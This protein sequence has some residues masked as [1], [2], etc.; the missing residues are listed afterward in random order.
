MRILNIA[1]VVSSVEIQTDTTDA[2]FY[3]RYYSRSDIFFIVNL[4]CATLTYKPL[5]IGEFL[6]GGGN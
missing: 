2:G 3:E 5:V 6:S 1:C 4:I